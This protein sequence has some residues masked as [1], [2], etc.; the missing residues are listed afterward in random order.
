MLSVAFTPADDDEY[1]R[2]YREEHLAVVASSVPGWRRTERYELQTA[3]LNVAPAPKN[4]PKF[5]TLACDYLHD[6]ITIS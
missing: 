5:L 4:P 6:F 1:D 3:L 2:W